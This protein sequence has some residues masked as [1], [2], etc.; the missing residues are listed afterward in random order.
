MMSLKSFLTSIVLCFSIA[1]N[2][3]A[4]ESGGS[5]YLPGFYGDF[6][7][8]LTPATGSYLSNF[9]GYNTVSDKNSN[10]NLTF[11]LPGLVHVT[12]QE[13]LG[14]RYWFG[15][16]P[17]VLRT[18]SK[19]PNNHTTRSGAGDMYA[20]PIALS[21]QWQEVSLLFFQ[22]IVMPTG[23]YQTQ[24]ALNSGRNYWTL[25]ENLA[26]TWQ[27]KNT[28]FELSLNLGY[29]INTKNQK[30]DYRTGDELH[31]DYCLGYYLTKEFAV[32]VTGSY[33]QQLT[34]DTGEGV[35]MNAIRGEY[36][37][38]GPALM[39]NTKL[40]DHEVMFSSKWLHEYNVNN[41]VAGDY[42]IL[43]TVLAF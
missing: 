31:F 15:F 5:S 41:H 18:E 10:S 26:L 24:R 12:N 27:P 2:L 32:G 42:I 37:S 29:M 7:M 38:I 11:E 9:L 13:V 6:G 25:D 30:T 35:P 23:T 20:M 43:R 4:A 39:Y 40:F 34:K 8:A 1:L 3:N 16:Y 14:G 28:P 19:T 17:Y 33:Y 21:W 22:G 36:S